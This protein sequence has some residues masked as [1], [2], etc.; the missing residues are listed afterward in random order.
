MSIVTDTER[1]WIKP[2]S[3]LCPRD[4]NFEFRVDCELRRGELGLEGWQ[5]EGQHVQLSLEMFI[6]CFTT[7]KWGLL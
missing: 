2:L 6:N 1:G 5:T 7:G 4:L 3:T